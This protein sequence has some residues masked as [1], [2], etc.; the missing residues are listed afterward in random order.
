MNKEMIDAAVFPFRKISEISK[1]TGISQKTLRD[2]CA[3]IEANAG[4]YGKAVIKGQKLRLI[5]IYAVYDFLENEEIIND[6]NER[7]L[8]PFSPEDYMTGIRI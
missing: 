7:I 6:G 4:R 5:N 1:L 8:K 2:I 3:G